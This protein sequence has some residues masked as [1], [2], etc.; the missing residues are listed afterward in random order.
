MPPPVARLLQ[1][2]FCFALLA[3][4]QGARSEPSYGS[5]VPPA[6]VLKQLERLAPQRPG[7]VDL[8]AVLVGG[9][10]SEDVFRK[11]VAAVRG[12]LEDR[13]DTAGR[14]VTLVN[15]RSLRE[16]EATLHSLAY[17]LKRVAAKMNRDEDVLFLH[18]TTH[19]TSS[20][21]LALTHRRR[22]LYG[23]S[24]QYLKALLDQAQIRFRV[25]VVSACYS[26]GFVAPL[27]NADTLVITAASADRQSFGC[28]ND[29]EITDFSRSFYLK[30]LNQ[31]LSFPA[32]AGIATQIIQ[33]IEQARGR[34]PSS[35]QMQLGSAIEDPLRSLE[36]RLG[37]R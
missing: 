32:A 25:V 30:A 14:T 27:A 28:G 1:A 18:L 20:H 11:E 17:V 19:G 24:P 16:P 29:S 12:V 9:D 31:T 23:I 37:G 34:K 15:H 5:E 7:T 13:F 26:G 4:T 3:G 35:P 2:A 22:E 36:R 33:E 6:A 21:V 8:Y 10:G